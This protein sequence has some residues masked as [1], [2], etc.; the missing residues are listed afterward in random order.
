[1]SLNK[2]NRGPFTLPGVRPGTVMDG[3]DGGA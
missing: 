2:W 1:M 3:A